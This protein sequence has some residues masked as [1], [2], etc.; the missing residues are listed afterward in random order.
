MK[1]LGGLFSRLDKSLSEYILFFELEVG[2]GRIEARR[3][4][5]YHKKKNAP[6]IR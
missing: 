4:G 1:G 2:I 6:R 5:N 3:A